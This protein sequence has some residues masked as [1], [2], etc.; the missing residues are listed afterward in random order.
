MKVMKATPAWA[1][2][3]GLVVLAFLAAWVRPGVG[4]NLQASGLIIG[5]VVLLLVGWWAG[6]LVVRAK[7]NMVDAALGGLGVGVVHA[8]A[9]VILFGYA[10]GQ[11]A[12][13]GPL[14][15]QNMIETIAAIAGAVA[16]SGIMK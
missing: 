12:S 3:V 8:I 11:T 13:I 16:G 2:A 5:S 10:T 9:A 15:D 6:V 4:T 7:G 14:L 1:L